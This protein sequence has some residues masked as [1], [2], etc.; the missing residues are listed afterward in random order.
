[1]APRLE[2]VLSTDKEITGNIAIQL[3]FCQGNSLMCSTII[4][5]MNMRPL[6]SWK[7]LKWEGKLLRR[8]FTLV[9]DHKGLEYFKTQ[10]V[11]SP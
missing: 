6:Q 4:A 11:L 7:P 8:K 2:S 3:D 9:T 10:T 5:H 1:M